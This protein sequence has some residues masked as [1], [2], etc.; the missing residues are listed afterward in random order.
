MEKEKNRP[1]LINLNIVEVTKF[2]NV[3]YMLF[4]FMIL[5]QSALVWMSVA[6]CKAKPR[7]SVQ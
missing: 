4:A 3:H 7:Y 5:F 6:Q 2:D 1:N